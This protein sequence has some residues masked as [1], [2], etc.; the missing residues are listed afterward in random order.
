MEYLTQDSLYEFLKKAFPKKEI[1]VNKTIKETNIKNR[2]DFRID[3]LL[4]E[5]DGYLH[6]SKSTTQK[7]DEIKEKIYT[8]HGFSIIHIPYFVQLSTDVIKLLFN[9]NMKW[10]QTYEHG[11][12]DDKALLPADFNEKGLIRFFEDIKKYSII[13]KEIYKSLDDKIEKL[14]IEVVLPPSIKST[15]ELDKKIFG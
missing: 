1:I 8:D 14:G 7:N 10:K 11:F 13:K 9:I 6:Y 2:P 12:I 15:K 3:N 4:I 5:F